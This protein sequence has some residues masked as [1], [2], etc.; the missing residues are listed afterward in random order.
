M[1]HE[2]DLARDVQA[3]LLPQETPPLKG[4]A[5]TGYCRPARLVGGDYY[6]LLRLNDGRFAFT[7]GDVSGKGIAAAVMMASIQTLLRSL[8]Q[9]TV[10]HD[11]RHNVSGQTL[12]DAVT[13]LNRALY[14]SST[15]DRY[16][17]LFCGI[18]DLER[19]QITYVNAGHVV[20][21]GRAGVA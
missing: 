4:L 6:D 14:E 20:P 17:T 18:L 12:A 7:L 19:M 9:R 11:A 2:L 10:A 5:A 1:R 13:E 16:S 8:L 21:P 15:A 3:R